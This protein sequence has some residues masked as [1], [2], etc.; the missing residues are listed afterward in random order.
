MV[1]VTDFGDSGYN[2]M[3][4][5]SFEHLLCLHGLHCKE[6]GRDEAKQISLLLV[7]SPFGTFS[8][9]L[10]GKKKKRAS[11]PFEAN[12]ISALSSYQLSTETNA[13]KLSHRN[14]SERGLVKC[15][16][17]SSLSFTHL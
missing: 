10:M 7:I 13:Q 3:T 11:I 16:F 17:P 8:I 15:S 12:E 1:L 5:I 2:R 14:K 9:S 6:I 4:E